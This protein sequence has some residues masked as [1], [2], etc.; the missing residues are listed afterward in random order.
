MNMQDLNEWPK[1]MNGEKIMTVIISIILSLA[2]Q[3]ECCGA[4]SKNDYTNNHL[5][6]PQSCSNSRTNNIHIYV[7]TLSN[8]KL[9]LLIREPLR[10]GTHFCFPIAV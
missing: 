6:I 9:Q 3:M 5:T 2:F 1:R 8:V 10:R 7:R 4:V